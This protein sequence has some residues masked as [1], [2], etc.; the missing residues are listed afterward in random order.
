MP[1]QTTRIFCCLGIFVEDR[2]EAALGA[3][4]S[5]P[6]STG[7]CPLSSYL[8]ALTVVLCG[9]II[10]LVKIWNKGSTDVTSEFVW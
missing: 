2:Q 8:C 9:K 1:N 3:F 7:L 10:W 6:T 5:P 4:S